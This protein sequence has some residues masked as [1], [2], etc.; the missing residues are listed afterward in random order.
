MSFDLQNFNNLSFVVL[1][2][3]IYELSLFMGKSL[4]FAQ[5]KRNVFFL[6]LNRRERA[7]CGDLVPGPLT[8]LAL[9]V[10][11]IYCVLPTAA[12]AYGAAPV[13]VCPH[14]Y[15]AQSTGSGERERE[16]API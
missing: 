10:R 7:S 1:K 9:P 4:Y 2:F 8:A 15:R 12:D 11:L 14:R 16:S 5:Y 13:A 6:M 3:L